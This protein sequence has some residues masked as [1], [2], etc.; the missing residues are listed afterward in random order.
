MRVTESQTAATRYVRWIREQDAVAPGSFH[1]T[2]DDA[3][4]LRRAVRVSSIAQPAQ[5]GVAK[6]RM[7]QVGHGRVTESLNLADL[8]LTAILTEFGS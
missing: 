3:A 5:A 8:P 7:P 6:P 2:I 4:L 1:C